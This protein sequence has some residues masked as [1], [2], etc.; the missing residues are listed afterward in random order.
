MR[1]KRASAGHVLEKD[2]MITPHQTA[3]F[4]ASFLKPRQTTRGQRV[5]LSV[6]TPLTDATMIL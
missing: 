6:A 2:H 3:G 1:D 5:R 4:R